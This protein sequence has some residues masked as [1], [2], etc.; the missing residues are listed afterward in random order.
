MPLNDFCFSRNLEI[1]VSIDWEL[2]LRV[3]VH[4]A[5]ASDDSYCKSHRPNTNVTSGGEGVSEF[6]LVRVLFRVRV[7]LE[8]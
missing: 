8:D 1:V 6:G 5:T 3:V 2:C 7:L 4:I